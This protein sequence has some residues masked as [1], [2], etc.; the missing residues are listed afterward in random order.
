MGETMIHKDGEIAEKKCPKC[1]KDM[2]YFNMDD[3][4]NKDVDA[5]DRDEESCIVHVLR[6]ECVDENCGYVE[7]VKE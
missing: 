1:G 5:E 7:E 2:E 6:L 3:D 4:L